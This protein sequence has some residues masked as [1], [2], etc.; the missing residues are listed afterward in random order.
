MTEIL[1]CDTEHFEIDQKLKFTLWKWLI[2]DDFDEISSVPSISDTYHWWTQPTFL[3]HF[4][5]FALFRS[6][7]A[8][9]NF[10]LYECFIQVAALLFFAEP[11]SYLQ[12]RIL[13]SR[14]ARSRAL[15]R[16]RL[17]I[18]SLAKLIRLKYMR[19]QRVKID[20]WP[21]NFICYEKQRIICTHSVFAVQERLYVQWYVI[22]LLCKFSFI[23][24][25]KGP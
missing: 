19:R 16:L 21:F 4:E 20:T 14:K 3:A 24:H 10:S 9:F 6:L 23:P 7:K 8:I 13:R 18:V 25:K 1:Y 15:N 12:Y 5:K 22:A 2:V 17:N 11:T